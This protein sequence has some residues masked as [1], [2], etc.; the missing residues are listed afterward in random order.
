MKAIKDRYE[1]SRTRNL[2]VFIPASTAIYDSNMGPEERREVA[3][4]AQI[5]LEVSR[6]Q[7]EERRK[8]YYFG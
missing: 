4:A 1:D 5:D 2:S 8:K 6:R 7:K 3:R